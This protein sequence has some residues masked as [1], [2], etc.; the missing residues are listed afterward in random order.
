MDFDCLE[1]PFT[2]ELQVDDE[3]SF[4]LP[5]QSLPP[6]ENNVQ[7]SLLP[8]NEN[9]VISPILHRQM[10]QTNYRCS[11]RKDRRVLGSMDMN[12]VSQFDHNRQHTKTIVVSHD[13]VT[14][15]KA[16]KN[17]INPIKEAVFGNSPFEV[18][19]S[20][21]NEM[22]S[23]RCLMSDPVFR[24]SP[25]QCDNSKI[26]LQLLLND[27][28]E[29]EN[30]TNSG[31]D[32]LS[33]HSQHSEV[34]IK[35]LPVI[36][37]GSTPE[38]MQIPNG[39]V[40]NATHAYV[41]RILREELAVAHDELSVLQ[42]ELKVTQ[43]QLEEQRETTVITSTNSAIDILSQQQFS[44]QAEVVLELEKQLQIEKVECENIRQ[45]LQ[46][47]TVN[48]VELNDEL[49]LLKDDNLLMN[50]QVGDLNAYIF[51]LFVLSL[52]CLFRYELC[53]NISCNSNLHW[54]QLLPHIQRLCHHYSCSMHNKL[55]M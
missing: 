8:N 51:M 42:D 29:E 7:P 18:S 28:E 2:L 37:S 22:S 6:H 20:N 33:N 19:D 5:S 53:L 12:A 49:K 52:S 3:I 21:D 43:Q 34:S 45:E 54:N 41:I 15:V 4:R 26:S 38:N 39:S 14:Q 55:P 27:S 9:D 47:Q 35:S 31:N 36:A 48:S 40:D 23:V 50:I 16:T 32:V 24:E 10:T 17:L 11:Q 30:T 46:R 25:Q 44:E 13:P 1:N